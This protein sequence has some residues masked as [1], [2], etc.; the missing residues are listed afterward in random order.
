M[1][2]VP[3]KTGMTAINKKAVTIQDHE[4]IGIFINDIPGAL[5]FKR[6]AII[7]IAAKIDE[8]PKIWMDTIKKSILGGP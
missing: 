5:Q 7:L 1:V 4:K 6:V 3:A 2:T 8:M